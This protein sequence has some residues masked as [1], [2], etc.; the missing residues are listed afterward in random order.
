MRL[1]KINLLALALVLLSVSVASAI[2]I[3]VEPGA[4]P[5]QLTV[6]LD[7]D[8]SGVLVQAV[9]IGIQT[10]NADVTYTGAEAAPL[11]PIVNQPGILLGSN[12]A[13]L[14]PT[15]A[16]GQAS[17]S[18]DVPA[19]S[20]RVLVDF[21]SATATNGLTGGTEN[22]LMATLNYSGP[23]YAETVAMVFGI[24]GGFYVSQGGTAVRVDG[25]V[26]LENNLASI[27]EP[28]TALLVGLGLVGLGVAG[29]RKA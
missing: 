4:N 5:N 13:W 29:R 8:N 6:Y 16:Y 24:D 23:V 18:L 27:P 17:N 11:V 1:I 25:D 10:S 26:A 20:T 19:G 12:F 28:T 14:S 7:L 2:T 22:Q 15:V 3:R 9:N 21:F